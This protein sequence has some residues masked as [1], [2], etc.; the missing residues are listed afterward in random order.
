M[1][2]F[3]FLARH[4]ARLAWRD[5]LAM[6]T[7]GRRGRGWKI[8]VGLAV[9]VAVL[10]AIAWRMIAPYVEAV[11]DDRATW[12]V[13][14]GSA[15]LAWTL[16]LSQALESITRTFYARADLDL[17]L[18]SPASP[19]AVFALRVAAAALGAM[20]LA[21]L[22]VGPFVNVL[23]WRIGSQLLLAYAVVA[24][25]AL[26]AT[27]VAV[28]LA[29]GM[30]R[31]LGARRTRLV[32]QIVAAIVGAGFVIGVQAAAIMTTGSLSRV[33]VFL[34]PAWVEAAPANDSLVWL[35]ARAALGN[36]SAAAAL[37]ALSVAILAGA[38]AVCGGGFA[39]HVLAAAGAA[40]AAGARRDPAPVFRPASQARALRHKEWLLLRRDPWLVSQ[41]LMQIL[42]LIPPA[43]LLW[44]KFGDEAGALAIL[45]P[46]IVM[47]AGQLAG[48]L[49]WLAI[50]GE[51][52]PDLVATA[53]IAP[54]AV[55]RA[56][57]EAVI[58]A[59][60]LPVLPLV[61]ALALAEPHAAL[62]TLIGCGLA[63]AGATAIQFF[64]RA[65]ARRS[66]FRRRQTASR[67]AT[68]AEALVS[69]SIA[70]AA[71]LAAAGSW[72]ALTP[73]A[74]AALLVWMAGR[75]ATLSKQPH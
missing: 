45:A 71:G 2:A 62:V 29:S 41:S 57:I 55:T 15:F 31:L 73:L 30:F 33:A 72:H 38:V 49:A 59:T 34:D 60:A 65:Q 56:K 52:A 25:L 53:P 40:Q 35:P 61:F 69:I 54:G 36:L 17:I 21:M 16:L 11:G 28:L 58:G 39:G 5:W 19:R 75:R 20:A 32:S 10:H 50:S 24:A 66:Q 64:F 9:V 13:L 7:G 23:A 18:S 1:T 70:A 37:L 12:L 26:L 4:E 8:S 68:F 6:L 44:R 74:L 48:G 46:V 22:A 42:Y 51:D 27:A 63:A 3:A 47:A 43:L 14:T 67:F